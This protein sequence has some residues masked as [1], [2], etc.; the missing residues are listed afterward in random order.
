MF[1]TCNLSLIIMTRK[2]SFLQ[3]IDRFFTMP[4]GLKHAQIYFVVRP[5]KI[6]IIIMRSSQNGMKMSLLYA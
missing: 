2:F 5:D 4:R 6:T 1:T 3:K